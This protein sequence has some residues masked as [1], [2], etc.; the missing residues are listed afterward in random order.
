M[1]N[2]AYSEYISFYLYKIKFDITQYSRPYTKH[3]RIFYKSKINT[4]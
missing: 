4:L 2:L 1:A 3:N